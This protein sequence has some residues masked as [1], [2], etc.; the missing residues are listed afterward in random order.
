MGKGLPC[1]LLC[2]VRVQ[3]EGAGGRMRPERPEEQRGEQEPRKLLAPCAHR[4][5][6]QSRGG[7]RREKV[8]HTERVG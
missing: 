7:Q 3:A 6:K 1:T 2:T 4:Q 5:G 8:R